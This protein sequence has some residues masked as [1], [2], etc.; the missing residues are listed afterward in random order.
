VLSLVRLPPKSSAKRLSTCKGRL[1]SGRERPA[2][3]N[4][5]P[6]KKIRDYSVWIRVWPDTNVLPAPKPD[7]FTSTG[8]S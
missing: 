2:V 5:P 7:F 1:S 6:C 3:D 4:R 8:G